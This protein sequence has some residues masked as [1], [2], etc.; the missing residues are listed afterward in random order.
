M[1]GLG[2]LE[3]TPDS[4]RIAKVDAWEAMDPR[5]VAL[6]PAEQFAA[7]IVGFT[8]AL[9]NR[10]EAQ[11]AGFGRGAQVA[12]LA[13]LLRDLR[14]AR[15]TLGFLESECESALARA[16]PARVIELPGLTLERHGGRKRTNWDH[17]RLL[18]LIVSRVPADPES[19]ELISEA[20][21]KAITTEV[22][23]CAGIAYW[24][25]G[26]L[27]ARDLDPA[28]FCDEEEGRATV[29]IREAG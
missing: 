10:I 23:A 19:G 6:P 21:Q 24:K 3:D 20:A 26:E 22:R 4:H 8:D 18:S 14:R 28:V 27:R 29:Q 11:I 17:D 9:A 25:V 16:M 1:A 2:W 12:A 15:A 7:Q 5:P 13:A